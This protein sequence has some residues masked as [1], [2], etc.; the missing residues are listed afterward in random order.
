MQISQKTWQI[1]VHGQIYE[2]DFEELKQWIVE[3]SVLPSDNVR[4]GN[5]RWLPAER[6]PALN[7]F[8]VAGGIGFAPPSASDNHKTLSDSRVKS[9]ET[10]ID[11]GE[12]PLFDI[13]A[14]KT[15]DS[16]I[17]ADEKFCSVHKTSA[18]AYACDIC[19]DYFCKSCPKNFGGKVRLCPSCGSLCREIDEATDARG[20]I[21][22]SIHKPYSLTDE[23]EADGA[24]SSATRTSDVL[25]YIVYPLKFSA[26]VVHVALTHFGTTVK[27][28]N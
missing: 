16:E 22:G 14:V 5:L 26:S 25:K 1:E 21:I 2:A 27:T 23:L 24:K 17:K 11:S 20:K 8:F 18:S 3:G 9:P 13:A 6:V 19:E 7:D 4:R 28:K 12:K 15:S 10:S